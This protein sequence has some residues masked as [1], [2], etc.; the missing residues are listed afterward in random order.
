[1]KYF[2][3]L[4]TN[5]IGVPLIAEQPE[6]IIANEQIFRRKR[7]RLMIKFIDTKEGNVAAAF[8]NQ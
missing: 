1:M 3:A 2:V 5:I 6:D 4:N 7:I 8:S